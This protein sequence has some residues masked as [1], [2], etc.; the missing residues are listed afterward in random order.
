M[1]ST[2]VDS[3]RRE[4]YEA[5]TGHSLRLQPDSALEC[6]LR[7]I[8]MRLFPSNVTGAERSSFSWKRLSFPDSCLIRSL[9]RE[10]AYLDPAVL[11]FSKSL[12]NQI[13][14][15]LVFHLSILGFCAFRAIDTNDSAW[16]KPG[17]FSS[18]LASIQSSD[19]VHI[20]ILYIVIF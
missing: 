20:R 17:N 6:R 9:S 12:L 10:G 11:Q 1:L 2:E 8:G 15:K 5:K 3:I 14:G 19:C 13:I 16:Y 18:V 7:Y 4:R